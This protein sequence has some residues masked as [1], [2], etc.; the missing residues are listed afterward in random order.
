[1]MNENGTFII[2]RKEILRQFRRP[3]FEGWGRDFF[4]IL[5]ACFVIEFL[6]VYFLSRRPVEEYNPERIARVQERFAQFVLE[7]ATQ[8]TKKM[9]VGIGISATGK[10][11]TTGKVSETESSGTSD[12]GSG[13]RGRSARGG[14]GGYGGLGSGTRRQALEAISREVSGKGLLAL[15]T[16]GS[17]QASGES[18]VY[19]ILNGSGDLSSIGS[20]DLDRILSSVDGLKTSGLSSGGTGGGIG[21]GTGSRL[22]EAREIRSEKLATIDDLVSGSE[23]SSK[24]ISRQGELR[25]EAPSEFTGQAHKNVY[26]SGQALREVLLRHV[27]AIQYCY[28]RELRRNPELRGKVVVRIT[29]APEGSVKNAVIVSSTLENERVERCIISR[30]LLWRDF[31]PIDPSEGDVTFRQVYTFGS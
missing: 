3:L 12:E 16:S 27:P 1:M 10:G 15:I 18:G 11:G 5:I 2:D 9:E 29:I 30:I 13:S 22:G 26:R 4:F 25:I 20:G 21:G 17:S 31:P 6:T 28:E 7:R 23:V 8:K 24:G 19:G 14:R